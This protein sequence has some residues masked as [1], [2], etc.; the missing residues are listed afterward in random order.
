MF[1]IFKNDRYIDVCEM[2]FIPMNVHYEQ[3]NG[4]RQLRW[5]QLSHVVSIFSTSIRLLSSFFTKHCLPLSLS[6]CPSVSFC[7]IPSHLLI[8]GISLR[9]EDVDVFF[10]NP[11]FFA[12]RNIH[13]PVNTSSD[14][15]HTDAEVP[16]SDYC[17]TQSSG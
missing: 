16:S 10:F 4:V 8:S 12:V 13:Y 15:F 2:C 6:F 14:H 17:R 5:H 9:F 3:F 11:K 7:G 1:H